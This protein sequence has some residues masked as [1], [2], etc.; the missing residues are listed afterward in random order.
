MF[1]IDLLSVIRSLNTVFTVIGISWFQTFA[2]FWIMYVFFW[3]FPRRP[4]CSSKPRPW[5]KYHVL[6]S[7]FILH[8]LHP[9]LEVGTDRRFRNVG[10]PQ[11][12]AGEI[13][14]RIHTRFKTRRKFEI[15]KISPVY[16][17]SF[18]RLETSLTY[19]LVWHRYVKQRFWKEGYLL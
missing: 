14:K 8:T 7:L 19:N 13:P 10:K 18:L 9:A 4:I 12:D 6:L 11:S 17:P 15:K 5:Y 16:P 3:V 1:R 2:V